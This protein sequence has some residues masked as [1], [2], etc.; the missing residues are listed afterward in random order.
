MLE[1]RACQRAKIRGISECDFRS[2][3]QRNH[4]FD[5]VVIK[6]VVYSSVVLIYAL[7]KFVYTEPDHPM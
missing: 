1:V 4:D 2:G 3:P 7:I 5:D 6:C